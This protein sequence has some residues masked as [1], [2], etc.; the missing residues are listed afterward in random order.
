VLDC[1]LPAAAFKANTAPPSSGYHQRSGLRRFTNGRRFPGSPEGTLRLSRGIIRSTVAELPFEVP[2]RPSPYTPGGR[3]NWIYAVVR[4]DQSLHVFRA[5]LSEMLCTRIFAHESNAATGHLLQRMNAPDAEW[6]SSSR[7]PSHSLE[8]KSLAARDKST[9]KC[10]FTLCKMRAYASWPEHAPSPIG[11]AESRCP[12]LSAIRAR[13]AASS[14][15]A[16]PASKT[17]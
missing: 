10:I 5:A 2:R 7:I 12:L 13:G 16:F 6:V 4:L 11:G 8:N 14:I 1:T 17:W 3:P 9:S 15:R